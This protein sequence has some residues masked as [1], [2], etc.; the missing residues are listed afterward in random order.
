MDKKNS[1]IDHLQNPNFVDRPSSIL[2]PG[3]EANRLTFRFTER[4]G[5]WQSVADWIRRGN[6][7]VTW[8]P[9]T[10]VAIRSDTN[11]VWQALRAAGLG[12]PAGSAVISGVVEAE[13]NEW[14]KSP[15]H[16][17]KRAAVISQALE[18]GTWL[19]KHR[20]D[21]ASSAGKGMVGYSYLLGI[22]RQL[23]RATDDGK[24]LLGTD[25]GD[26]CGTMNAIKNQIG[27]RAMDLA[28]K[29]RLDA[30]DGKPSNISDELHCLTA[31]SYAL[32][33]NRPS[34]LL[35]ADRDYVEI[36][37]KAQWFFDTHYRAWLAAKMIKNGSYGEPTRD[38]VDTKGYFDGPVTLYRRATNNLREVLPRH[39]R[40]ITAGVVYVAPNGFVQFMVFQF[41]SAMLDLLKI[42]GKSDG[43]CTDEFGDSNIHVDLGPIKPLLDGNYLGIGKDVTHTF[44]SWMGERRIS[45]LDLEHSLCCNERNTSKIILL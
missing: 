27:E 44:K 41:E 16:N 18:E 23:A 17:E 26:A 4:L 29:G 5:G 39:F 37:F 19:Q 14:L 30:R 36:F 12:S 43:R 24:T 35:T 20:F 8:F 15:R 31:I 10:N 21:L 22:R 1:L 33:N 38:L 42:R 13:L 9:D 34:L 40:P 25:A 6:T 2:Y 11:E 7:A 3:D 45:F 28:R 32:A